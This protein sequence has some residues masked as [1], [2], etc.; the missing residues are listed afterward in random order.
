MWKPQFFTKSFSW[1]YQELLTRGHSYNGAKVKRTLKYEHLQ[2]LLLG[3]A[4]KVHKWDPRQ[5]AVHDPDKLAAFVCDLKI[6]K[7]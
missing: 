2:I 4:S 3:A 7:G 5:M 1:S 6:Q